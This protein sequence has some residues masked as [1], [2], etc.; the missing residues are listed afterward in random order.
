MWRVGWPQK[1]LVKQ[2]ITKDGKKCLGVGR[3]EL[4]GEIGGVGGGCSKVGGWK[5]AVSP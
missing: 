4:D 5:L 1:K 3:V 2:G